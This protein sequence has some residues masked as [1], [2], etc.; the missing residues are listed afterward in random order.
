MD[1]LLI[2][3]ASGMKARRESLEMIAN[4]S[5]SSSTTGYKSD[6][7]FY[8]LYESASRGADLPLVESQWTDFTQGVLVPSGN[9]LQVALAG[10]GFF[11]LNSPTGTVYA[12]GGEVQISKSN[13]IQTAEGYTV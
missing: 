4:N 9:S 10:P 8:T 5:A 2:S 12:R 1:P 7:E 11:A 6:R 13:Q 3:A